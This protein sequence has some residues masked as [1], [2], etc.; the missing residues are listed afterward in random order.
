MPYYVYRITVRG[1]RVLLSEH[2]YEADAWA[3]VGNKRRIVTDGRGVVLRRE[4]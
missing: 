1:N 2:L 4:R 3:F